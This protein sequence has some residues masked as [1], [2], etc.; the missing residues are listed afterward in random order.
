MRSAYQI[1]EEEGI[2]ENRTRSGRYMGHGRI[3]TDLCQIQSFSEKAQDLGMD[4]ENKLL[5]FEL[6]EVDKRLSKKMKLPIGTVL[7]KITRVRSV[8]R[9]NEMF[10]VAIEY[11]YI[12]EEMAG[13]LISPGC[14]FHFLL[15]PV[16][17]LFES[18][19]VLIHHRMEKLQ[20]IALVVIGNAF[21]HHQCSP[22]IHLQRFRFK[23]IGIYNLYHLFL[24]FGNPAV[25][26]G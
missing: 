22:L 21:F 14:L 17:P 10:P 15:N 1:L 9:G 24:P 8:R 4:K 6:V 18:H 11:A 12:P 3:R 19:P 20:D 13:K 2:I 5:A 7:N 25:F 26:L 16:I 23:F